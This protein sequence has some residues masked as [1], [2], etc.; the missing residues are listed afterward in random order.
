VTA[1]EA[2]EITTGTGRLHALTWGS[3]D[4]PAVVAVHGWLDNAA[5]F[6][7]LAEHLPGVRLIALDLAG[8]GHSEHLPRGASYPFVDWIAMVDEVTHVLGLP[9]FA[10]LGHSMGAAISAL[11]A[12]T[13]PSRVTRLVAIEGLGPLSEPVEQAPQRLATALAAARTE[14][15]V[16]PPRPYASSLDKFASARSLTAAQAEPLAQRAMVVGDDGVR[17]RFDPRL[18]VSSRWRMSEAM[19]MAY[20]ARIACPTLVIRGTQGSGFAPTQGSA[21]FEAVSGAKL[22]SLEGGHHLHVS[23]PEAVAEHAGPWLRGDV[24]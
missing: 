11:L 8:H 19:V 23:H 10:L 13:F 20:L 18:R 16:S 6:S 12:G 17:W 9:Q 21:R 5:S 24:P 22:V 7:A 15:P 14:P 1:G 3:A 4:A 2:I